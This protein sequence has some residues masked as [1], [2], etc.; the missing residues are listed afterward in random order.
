MSDEKEKEEKS[1]PG[2]GNYEA[3]KGDS[4]KFKVSP[5]AKFMKSKRL[6]L[7][8]IKVKEKKLIPGPGK[9]NADRSFEHITK[10]IASP[11]KGRFG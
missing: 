9:Y 5:K 7:I 8:D 3:G 11:K 4:L 10:S 1:K 6:S 2:P